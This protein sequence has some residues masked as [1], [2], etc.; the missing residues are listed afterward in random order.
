[1]KWTPAGMWGAMSRTT[2]ALTEPTS[3]TVAP[4]FRCGPM[5]FATAAQAPIGTQTITRSAPATAAALLSTTS[6]ASPS[7]RMRCRVGSERDV[8][9]ISRTRPSARAARAIEPPIRPTPISVR[10]S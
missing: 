6:S 5:S 2:A 9:T 4:G 3:E 10:R 7:S 1:M 8:A